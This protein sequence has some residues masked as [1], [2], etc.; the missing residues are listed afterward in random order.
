MTAQVEHKKNSFFLRSLLWA[1]VAVYTLVLPHVILIYTAIAK[2]FSSENAGKVSIALIVL[3]GIAYFLAVLV[4]KKGIK[5]LALLVPCAIIVWV[6]ISIESN[7]N[8][9]IHI[10][11]YIIMT[12]LLF[13]VLAL[14]YKDKGI[15]FLVFI[16]AALLGIVDEMM[17]GIIPNRHYGWQDMIMNSAAALMGIFTLAGLR[18][19]PTGDWAWTGGLKEFKPALGIM[20]F[21]AAGAVLTCVYL[22]DV[23]ALAFR[24]VYPFWLLGWNGLFLIT[25]SVAIFFQKRL[26]KPINPGNDEDSNPYDQAMTARLWIL[27]PLVILII[28]HT[29]VLLTAVAGLPFN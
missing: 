22:F 25:G 8:K 17:Q 28:I 23:K 14:D 7:P 12:W 19:A 26:Y 6:F 9:Y 1:L 24:N 20:V 18:K 16:C 29:L 27:C 21:G 2:H 3:L 4:L 13:E 15:F 5:A 11:E 10:P